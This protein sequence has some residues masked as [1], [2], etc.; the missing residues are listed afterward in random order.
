MFTLEQFRAQYVRNA[1][2]LATMVEAA[3]VVTDAGK[4]G[5]KGKRYRGY[6][7]HQLV[8]KFVATVASSNATDDE[9][10]P[11]YTMLARACENTKRHTSPATVE[12]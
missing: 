7:F 4:G 5:P 12:G 10:R 3:R 9:L 11:M 1:A 8:S 2:Q 6:F